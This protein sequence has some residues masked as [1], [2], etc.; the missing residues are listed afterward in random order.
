MTEIGIIDE[1]LKI[2]END[3]LKLVLN[4]G[5]EKSK[6]FYYKI[7]D[8]Y[9]NYVGNCGIRLSDDYKD[10]VLG[11]I[12]Y[13]IFEEYRGNNY[14]QKA[15]KLL[16]FVALHYN[17]KELSITASPKNIASNKT[18]QNLGA[19]FIEIKKVP[20]NSILYKSNKQVNMYNW[21]I[22]SEKKI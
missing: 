7:Y 6:R 12:E 3:D 17:V 2:I 1:S 19:R 22:E 9:N 13:E 16:T 5:I 10:D 4:L 8:K 20:E 18:I 14:S 21:N 15:C 11:N